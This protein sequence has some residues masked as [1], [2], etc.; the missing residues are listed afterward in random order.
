MGRKKIYKTTEEIRQADCIKSM[1]YYLK[2]KEEIQKK[3]LK[4]YYDKKQK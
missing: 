4:R 1:R 3:N 2:N